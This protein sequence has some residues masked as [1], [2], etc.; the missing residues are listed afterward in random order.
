[1]GYLKQ[2]VRRELIAAASNASQQLK[3]IDAVQ[4][5]E[6]AYHF[7]KEIEEALQNT[8]DNYLDIDDINDDLYS[9][10]LRF[11]LPRQQW[12]NISCGKPH[13]Y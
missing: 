10:A 7:Q 11:R 2:E 1:M 3:F 8:Y 6:V 13:E 12:Y 4:G 5:L 9:V